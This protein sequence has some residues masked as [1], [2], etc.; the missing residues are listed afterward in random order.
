MAGPINV[1][2]QLK[3]RETTE[4]LIR[5]FIKKCKKEKIIEEYRART[6]YEKPSTIKRRK[7]ARSRKIAKD[8]QAERDKQTN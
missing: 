6:H 1:E 4:R 8:L 5:R 3:D 2:V 7:K